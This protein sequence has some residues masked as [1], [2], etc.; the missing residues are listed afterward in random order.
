MREGILKIKVNVPPIPVNLIA[1]PQLSEQLDRGLLAG[2]VFARRLTLISA[3]AGAGK[4]TA[5]RSW[6][7]GREERLAWY[8]LDDGDQEPTRFW[9]YLVTALQHL[10][11]SLGRVSLS[12]LRS[13]APGWESPVEEQSFLTPLL[14]ELFSLNKSLFLVIDD[15]HLVDNP[16]IHKAMTFFIENLPPTLHLV[17]ITRSEPPWPLAR[18]RARGFL[19]ELRQKDLKFSREETA[20]LLAAT[21]SLSISETQ[22]DALYRKTDGW[23][24]GLQLASYALSDRTDPD[25]FIEHFSGSHRHIFHFL[26]E[27]VLKKQPPQVRDFLQQTAILSRFNASLCDE[28][29]GRVGSAEILENLERDNLF[30]IPLDDRGLWYRYHPLFTDLLL[31]QLQQTQPNLVTVLHERAATWHAE[32]GEPGLA[33]RHLLRGGNLEKAARMVDDHHEAIIDSEG[34][35]LIVETLELLPPGVLANHPHLVVQKA[36]F[37]LVHKGRERAEHILQLAEETIRESQNLPGEIEGMLAVVQ[38][39]VYINAHKFSLALEKA[40]QALELLP[41]SHNYWRSKVGIILGDARLFSGKPG[42][43]YPYYTEA[44]LN[45]QAYGNTYLILTTGFKVATSLYF[46]GKLREAEKLTRELLHT[47][48]NKGFSTV[49]RV[50]LIWVLLGEIMREKGSLEEA[51]RCVERGLLLSEPE[52]PSLGW[53][54]LFRAALSFSQ[55]KHEEILE[56]TGAIEKL[57]R[58]LGLPRFITLPAVYWQARALLA[59][60]EPDRAQAVLREAGITADRE[61]TGGE[62]SCVLTL[63]RLLLFQNTHNLAQVRARLDGIED[64]AVSGN[65]QRIVIETLLLRALLEERA[66]SHAAAATAP[67]AALE[68]G[69]MLGFVQVFRDEAKNLE[70]I[71]S[72]LKPGEKYSVPVFL[73]QELLRYI[74]LLDLLKQEPVPMPGSNGEENEGLMAGEERI[75]ETIDPSHRALVEELNPRELEIIDFMAGGLSNQEIAEKLYLSVGTVKWYTSNI[76]GK[77]GVRN[78]AAAVGLAQK[79][80]LIDPGPYHPHDR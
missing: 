75:D 65:H 10:E 8:T 73:D 57:H 26:T 24:T 6:L 72:R 17:T 7:A 67:G 69:K 32:A 70:S 19:A 29:T 71:L 18:W 28:V 34:P 30:V 80:K 54:Y 77:L 20:R 42:E 31:H 25:P 40:E 58:Q 22:L 41:E 12:I 35:G 15:Y 60:G 2:D 21:G 45:N 27:E 79:L 59:L 46:L 47:A 37:A 9:T 68:R 63:L 43:A 5:A 74:D 14:N 66:G 48:R 49:P 33:V 76:Y 51:E 55:G 38:A 3:P 16:Q 13:T 62:E 50:G 23:I 4:T 52:K 36:W 78:R 61:V 56:A 64:L 39:Y 44:H 11:A 53:N 1:R